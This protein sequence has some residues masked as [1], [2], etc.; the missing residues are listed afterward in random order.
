MRTSININCYRDLLRPVLCFNQWRLDCG[1]ILATAI[2][3]RRFSRTHMC[4][5]TSIGTIEWTGRTGS[6]ALY[7]VG[8]QSVATH[9]PLKVYLCVLCVRT[10]RWYGAHAFHTTSPHRIV[11]THLAQCQFGICYLIRRTLRNVILIKLHCWRLVKYLDARTIVIRTIVGT[12]GVRVVHVIWPWT[13][14]DWL[15]RTH[16]H[17]VARQARIGQT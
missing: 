15:E 1:L 16:G 17:A 7:S 2:S 11:C 4:H 3:N 12:L 9:L 14:L 8:R 10:N 6:N 5:Q 13:I